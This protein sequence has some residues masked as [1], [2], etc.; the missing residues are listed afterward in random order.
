M[1]GFL[2]DG[3]AVGQAFGVGDPPMR[4]GMVVLSES[5]FSEHACR[6]YLCELDGSGAVYTFGGAVR[7]PLEAGPPV[8]RPAFSPRAATARSK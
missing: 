7:W 5:G 3:P 4:R 8:R 1:L 2:K 6:Y